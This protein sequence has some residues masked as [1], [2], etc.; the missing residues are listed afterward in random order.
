MAIQ[1]Q[2][3]AVY[4]VIRKAVVLQFELGSSSKI[5]LEN[6]RS[7]AYNSGRPELHCVL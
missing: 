2:T 5:L 1:V 6:I 4:F 3:P 7:F